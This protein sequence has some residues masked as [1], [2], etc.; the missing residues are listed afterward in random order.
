MKL[1]GWSSRGKSFQHKMPSVSIITA[2]YNRANVLRYSIASVINSTLQDWELIIIGDAC[3]DHTEE[4]VK[5]F[6]DPRIIFKN[7]EQNFGE[8]SG[9]NNVGFEMASA[10]Y[11]AY[12]HQDDLY[13][14]EHLANSFDF[15]HS[16]QADLVFSAM[17]TAKPMTADEIN[18]GRLKIDMYRLP[19]DKTYHPYLFVHPSSWLFKRE[20]IEDVGGW[21]FSNECH[22]TPSQELLFRFYKAKKKLLFHP[23]IGLLSVP[24]GSRKNSYLGEKDYENEYY[25]KLITETANFHRT[26]YENTAIYQQNK[27]TQSI[28]KPPI[29]EIL[30]GL[31]NWLFYK[32]LI[33][34]GISPLSI[35]G[36][37]KFG[38][39]GNLIKQL[40]KYRGLPEKA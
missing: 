23:K 8:Q 29:N 24:S 34:F 11:I 12:L 37:F 39:R 1:I 22:Y 31:F 4:V 40:R 17:A 15:L 28:L 9:P 7:L 14:P 3:T 5:G 30:F 21:K 36:F 32:L 13:F 19:P 38:K 26:I 18:S 27:Y 2:T 16:T 25:G 35:T 6:N 20:L 33:K 10:E